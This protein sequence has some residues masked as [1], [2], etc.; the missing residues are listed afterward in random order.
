MGYRRFTPVTF[1]GVVFWIRLSV[2]YQDVKIVNEVWNGDTY[3]L[4]DLKRLIS[5]PECVLDVGGHIGTFGVAAKSL[6]PDCTLVALEPVE[7]SYKLYRKNLE[8]NGLMDGRCHILN[9]ALSYWPKTTPMG[10]VGAVRTTGGHALRPITQI[11][12]YLERDWRY[13]RFSWAE[14]SDDKKSPPLELLTIA[15][16][17]DR[18]GVDHFDLAKWDCEGAEVQ[19]FTH[20]PA[21]D[22]RRF[23][24]MV[25]EYHIGHDV[26]LVPKVSEK[27]SF[28]REAKRRFPHLNWDFGSSAL[29]KFRAW[30]KNLDIVMN[31]PS[32]SPGTHEAARST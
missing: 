17:V 21:Q 22:A 31:G 23:S 12:S 1:P 27:I 26:G 20:M 4:R 8:A 11:A 18:T 16:L 10:M 6:W 30:P 19:A 25:G 24:F 5:P 3:E 2:G 28:W 7:E 14:S 13:Q 9:A 29:G 32:S 15:D